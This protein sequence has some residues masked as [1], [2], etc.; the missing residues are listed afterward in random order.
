MAD[1]Q[2]KEYQT[3]ILAALLHDVGKFMNRVKGV[4]KRHPL[5]SAEY[6]SD[7]K[8]KIKP[9]WAE[10]DLLRL[11]CQRHHEDTRLPEDILVQGINDKH[12]RALAYIVSRADNYSSQERPDEEHSEADFR[13]TR[14]LSVF[15]KVDIGKGKTTPLYYDLKP[16]S[17]ED[18]FPRDEESLNLA[19]NYRRLGQ[20]GFIEAIDN[21]NPPNFDAFFNGHLSIL[22][23]FLWCVPSDTTIEY[24]DISLFDHL[25]TTSAI[26]A[27]LYRYHQDNIDE[28]GIKN[29]NKEKFILLG[30]DLS[31]IQKFIFEIKSTNPKK[32]SNILRGRS[33]YLSLLTECWAL[34]IL[35]RFNLPLSCRI[36]NAGGRF[37]L[38]LPNIDAVK[39]ELRE[40]TTEINSFFFQKFL[41]KIS[42][43]LDYSVTLAG[44]D[45]ESKTRRIREK[46]EAL[47]LALE[48][49]KIQK[50]INEGG[51]KDTYF[52][53]SKNGPCEFCG[54]YP[55]LEP[56]GRCQICK[57]AE[58]IGQQLSK[59]NFIGFRRGRDTELNIGGIG[60][61]FLKI[62]DNPSM[63]FLLEKISDE[64]DKINPG[65]IK[66]SI[67]NFLPLPE[68]KEV[69]CEHSHK[70]EKIEC[71]SLC[72]FCKDVCKM[73]DR[74]KLSSSILTFQCLATHTTRENNGK[75]VNHLGLLKADIDF[76]GMIF[77]LGID[78]LSVSRY[79]FLSR[80]FDLFF[81]GWTRNSI[82]NH[83]KKIYTVYAGGDDILLIGPWEQICEFATHLNDNFK[84]FVG[85]NPNI[86]LSCGISLMRPHASVSTTVAMAE[87]NLE[88]SKNGGRD[89]LTL[90]ETT[91]KWQEIQKLEEYKEFL[92][93]ELRNEGS[94]INSAFLY[95]LLKYQFMFLEAE[96]KGFIEG[97]KFHS[98]MARDVKHNIEKKEN[99]KVVN[100]DVLDKLR[101]L[102]AMG[103]EQNKD[104][105][106][107]IKIPIH[108]ILY[109]NRGG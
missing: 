25:S 11:L 43:N 60:V 80:M 22:E 29:D 93:T 105:M 87:H 27:C 58:D 56:E 109:K 3:V 34:K 30:G 35:K 92:N 104:L 106:R 96:D 44:R 77:S 84:R 79:A 107:N 74:K 28:Q 21:F 78:D 72:A 31:G 71:T 20:E 51:F 63:Y 88:R 73:E 14:L 37:I 98:A 100:Q 69:C 55:A 40:I 85:N 103:D 5:L 42:L 50:P 76:L 89:R 23:E 45:F 13:E 66:R 7:I 9:D 68:E 36:M 33:F 53:L 57:D 46:L 39:D 90:F 82:K 91:A 49:K 61:D 1:T 17:P 67:A 62:I 15:S 102:Y 16:L 26:A 97:Y 81:T 65:Y 38:L 10:L 8:G 64:K 4:R 94:K 12:N 47:N 2:T 70:G 18:V 83:Y 6:V 95:R 54:I 24:S 75:G 99:G 86:T 32:L 41:G 101:P 59:T 108:W 19:Y 48:K 52:L